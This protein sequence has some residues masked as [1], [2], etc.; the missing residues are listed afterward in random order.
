LGGT[1][2][3]GGKERGEQLEKKGARSKKNDANLKIRRKHVGEGER[4]NAFAQIRAEAEK[5][6]HVREGEKKL[7]VTW[8]RGGGT[9]LGEK[10]NRS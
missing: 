3:G 7:Q 5:L 2:L 10:K 1:S 8:G 9:G 4:F 6:F